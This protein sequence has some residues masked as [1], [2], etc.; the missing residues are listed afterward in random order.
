M[1][2]VRRG[3]AILVLAAAVAGCGGG[4]SSRPELAG[5]RDATVS[6]GTAAFTLLIDAVVGGRPVRASETGT[7]SFTQRRAHLYKLVPGVGLPQEIILDGPYVYTNANVEAAMRD[8]TVPPWT[9][10]DTRRLSAEELKSRPDELEHVRALVYLAD[11]VKA[12][13][14]IGIET[15]EGERATRF[16]GRVDPA[17]V[18]AGAPV[19]LRSGIAATLRN[20]YPA[21]PFSADFW[22]DGEGRISRVLVA[23]RTPGGTRI[24]LDGRLSK[25]GAKIDLTLPDAGSIEDI[26]P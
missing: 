22:L 1:A 17:R 3:L 2:L 10:L 19:E 14:H 9:K 6:E 16:R 4:T 24:S 11:G 21:E 20:D 23:Y 13:K 15:V 12:P 18:V 7:I 25:F 8:S 5:A 26:S